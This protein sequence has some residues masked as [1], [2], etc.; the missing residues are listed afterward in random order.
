LSLCSKVGDTAVGTA[1]AVEL[2]SSDEVD[3]S[4]SRPKPTARGLDVNACC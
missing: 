3:S 2:R 4:R 1:E